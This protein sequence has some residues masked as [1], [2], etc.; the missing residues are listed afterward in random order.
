MT[1]THVHNYYDGPIAGEV[2]RNNLRYYWEFMHDHNRFDA[3]SLS[4][5]EWESIG[6]MNILGTEDPRFTELCELLERIRDRDPAFSFKYEEAVWR[7]GYE[8]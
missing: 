3:W 1:I 6:G 2:V 5:E 8:Y 4:E 7:E